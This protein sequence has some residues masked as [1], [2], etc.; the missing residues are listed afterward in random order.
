MKITS[1]KK[2]I[3]IGGLAGI[4][5]SCSTQ[6]HFQR[7]SVNTA[8]LY[9]DTTTTDSATIANKPWRELFTET[10]LQQLIQEGLDNNPDLQVAI[11]RTKEAEAYFSQSKAALLPAISAKGTGT[12]IRNPES[13]YPDGP[14][15]V[16]NFQLGAE[17]SWEIDLWGKLSSSKRSAY[18]NL[19][20]SDA[21]RKAVETRLIANIV[22]AYYNLVGL[23]AKLTITKETVKNNIDLVETIKVLKQSGRVTGAAVVQSEAARYA[24]EVTIPDLE[25][26]I[27]ETENALSLLL[28]RV[29]GTIQRGKI[30]DQ[31]ISPALQTGVPAQLLD[32]RP[33]VM[34]AEYNVMGAYEM[35]NSARAYFYPALTLTAST[36]FAAT[37]LSK[38]LD[39]KSFAANIIGGLTQPI[40]N[41]RINATRLK[42]AQAQQEESLIN[43]RNTLLNAGQEVNNALGL[44][45]S[46]VQKIGLRKMQLDALL[47]SVDYTKELL[48]YGSATYTEVLNAQTSLLSAQLSSVNDKLQQLNAVVTLYRALGGGWK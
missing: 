46:S 43:L 21:G 20:A 12:Y 36:G 48:T 1:F 45:D 16:N 25:Q 42:V 11:Q 47:K 14:R 26:Q 35:T 23:D 28:G 33:D 34:Q 3:L 18:A 44:Y 10:H 24:A 2:I 38:L 27:R 30:D 40:F 15:E 22:T 41:K 19:L 13:I 17:A 6:R 32:N 7:E 8:G 4:L 31:N 5:L 29:P 37:D 39:P 9:G